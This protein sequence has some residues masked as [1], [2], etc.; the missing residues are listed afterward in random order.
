MESVPGCWD[1]AGLGLQGPNPQVHGW[2]RHRGRECFHSHPRWALKV[3]SWQ[4][5]GTSSPG[6][7]NAHGEWGVE[8]SWPE[9]ELPSA[10]EQGA[11]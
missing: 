8:V 5:R 6:R 10:G 1:T 11:D 9:A 3:A 2:L 4:M 7:G